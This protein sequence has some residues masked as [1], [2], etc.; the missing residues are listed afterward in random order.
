M[1]TCLFN[2]I[3]LVLSTRSDKYVDCLYVQGGDTC[4]LSV[5]QSDC[6]RLALRLSLFYL[7]FGLVFN[8]TYGCVVSVCTCG[9]A[10]TVCTC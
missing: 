3:G 9:G 7:G 2:G 10:V 1:C 4:V 8:C 6:L 5:H